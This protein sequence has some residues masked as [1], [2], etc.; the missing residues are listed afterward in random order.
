MHTFCTLGRDSR[1][2]VSG[3]VGALA[4]GIGGA[5]DVRPLEC[6]VP[7][8]WP[9]VWLGEAGIFFFTFFLLFIDALRLGIGGVLVV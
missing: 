2:M 6:V 5:G 8:G 9:L 7:V 4:G 1:V 3:D